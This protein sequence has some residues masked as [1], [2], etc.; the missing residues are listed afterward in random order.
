[1]IRICMALYTSKKYWFHKNCPKLFER[2]TGDIDTFLF[3]IQ[4]LDWLTR[5]CRQPGT[6]WIPPAV[7]T[8]CWWRGRSLHLTS[9]LHP[10]Q[11]MFFT[12]D[13]FWC[14][15][16]HSIFISLMTCLRMCVF[17]HT[18]LSLLYIHTHSSHTH[19]RCTHPETCMHAHVC[20]FVFTHAWLH[21]CKHKSLQLSYV[22]LYILYFVLFILLRMQFVVIVV[23][24]L[25]V[26]LLVY[27]SH[28]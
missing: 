19:T 9:G 21:M 3:V 14:I 17:N 25:N 12:V 28:K 2:N 24:V 18:Y 16:L 22:K 1:M 27:F 5:H 26:I 6:T 4:I 20:S 11:R 13:A 8:V 15:T 7:H 23:N 10:S